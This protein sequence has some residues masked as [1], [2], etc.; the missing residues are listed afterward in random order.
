M[1]PIT[2]RGALLL[3]LATASFAGTNNDIVEFFLPPHAGWFQDDLFKIVSGNSPPPAAG[4][5]F[6][7]FTKRDY[8]P[9]VVYRGTD[10]H[11]HELY[12]NRGW[13]QDDL[14]RL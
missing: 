10:N 4:D 14:F 3:L 13:F 6:P 8:I 1:K 11:I 5:P 7:Y 12:L 9:R 2:L